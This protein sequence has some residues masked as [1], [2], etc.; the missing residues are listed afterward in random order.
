[1]ETVEF[2]WHCVVSRA[3]HDGLR[4]LYQ[5]LKR[6][7]ANIRAAS[8]LGLEFRAHYVDGVLGGWQARV[9]RL[10]QWLV[11]ALAA[12]LVLTPVVEFIV[13]APA[14]WYGLPT[15]AFPPAR[16]L[17]AAVQWST[18]GIVAG[19][20]TLIALAAL[21]LLLTM[22]PRPV[23]ITFRSVVLLMLQPLLIMTIGAFAADSVL[24]LGLFVVLGVF[25]YVVGGVGP[26]VMCAAA[27][28]TL[29]A[30]RVLWARPLRGPINVMIDAF[31][32]LGE[33]GY[34]TRIQQA[35][36]RA[37]QQAR[38]STG[39]D[40]E[41]VL[42]GQG[43]G[44][45]IALDS[46]MHSR[47]W[48]TT[49]CVFLVTMGSPLRRYFLPFFPRILFPET[50]EDVVDLAAGRLHQFRWMNVY[51]RGDYVGADLG[52]A[53]FNGCDVPVEHQRR[54][55]GGHADY[56]LDFEARHAFHRGLGQITQ[57]R[58]LQVPMR[59]AAHRLPHPPGLS[60][61]FRVPSPMRPLVGTTLSVVTF[62][63]MLWWVATG[64]G[65]LAPG[66]DDTPESLEL[67]VVVDAAATHRR[68]TV[69]HAHGLTFVHH[70]EFEF[71]DPDGVVKNLRIK[72][73]ASDAFLD[74]PH[75]FD[76][77]ALTRQARAECAGTAG[78]VWPTIRNM[79]TPCTLHGVRVRYYPADMTSFDL[80]DFPR[81]RFG[82]NPVTGW[83]EAGL[84]AGVLSALLFI[85]LVFGARLFALFVG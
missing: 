80:P 8:F 39:E 10:L 18:L 32:Y 64:L 35:L 62:G 23:I 85:P 75:P 44:T 51:R 3:S 50:I 12:M 33:Q 56:W 67:G 14:A 81:R 61:E 54:V 38:R 20:T 16:W 84:V 30:L 71:T 78:S 55:I 70:W 36:D 58:P 73:H 65:V 49:D 69:K 13:L 53:A 21:R 59:D 6:N 48:R 17:A 7:A 41:F 52:L 29:L 63:G 60:E 68:E 82:S 57:V 22:S 66:I 45:V 26:L 5:F 46:V 28:G 9:H 15:D 31:R 24:L 25:S 42:V 34:R 72:R 37:I 47:N 76:D 19:F 83:T 77:R 40:H 79:E 74:I 1:V 43:L 11:P 27:F 4:N 2:D